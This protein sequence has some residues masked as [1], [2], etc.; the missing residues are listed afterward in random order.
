MGDVSH[1]IPSLFMSDSSAAIAARAPT[2]APDFAGIVRKCWRI[3]FGVS[4]AVDRLWLVC[5]TGGAATLRSSTGVGGSDALLDL[6]VKM[7][8]GKGARRLYPG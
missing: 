2:E 6:E 7:I 1:L 3:V 4:C 8:L 5:D